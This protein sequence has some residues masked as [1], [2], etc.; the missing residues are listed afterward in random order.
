MPERI[1]QKSE[2]RRRKLAAE[3]ESLPAAEL[4]QQVVFLFIELYRK[5]ENITTNPDQELA[6]LPEE[7]RTDFQW[8][9]GQL[10]SIFLNS[11]DALNPDQAKLL[12]QEQFI[13][14][15]GILSEI[16]NKH[17]PLR[18]T[19]AVVTHRFN[20][21]LVQPAVVEQFESLPATAKLELLS[22]YP[23]LF[24]PGLLHLLEGAALDHRARK[25]AHSRVAALRDKLARIIYFFDLPAWGKPEFRTEIFAHAIYT[26]LAENET[27]HAEFK[28]ASWDSLEKIVE[29]ILEHFKFPGLSEQLTTD[30]AVDRTL[31]LDP[32]NSKTDEILAQFIHHNRI[33]MVELLRL[34]VAVGLN[35][36]ELRKIL[37]HQDEAVPA[38]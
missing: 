18:Q 19:L 30:L 22:N 11:V 27:A 5:I 6:A 12:I 34:T 35:E 16:L 8:K 20:S 24:L 14:N 32:E 28:S 15:L 17:Y 26:L 29:N 23:S 37:N 25:N 13:T 31:E 33:S 38:E 1:N 2:K 3:S 10:I 7:E 36:D 4:R 21:E 9:V